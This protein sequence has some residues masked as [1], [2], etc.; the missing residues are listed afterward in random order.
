LHLGIHA[1]W[2]R[3]RPTRKERMRGA[4]VSVATQPC[5]FSGNGVC[6]SCIRGKYWQTNDYNR[7]TSPYQGHWQILLCEKSHRTWLQQ[8]QDVP[9][10]HDEVRGIWSWRTVMQQLL[11]MK[12]RER[13]PKLCQLCRH[14]S[15]F[16]LHSCG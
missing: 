10:W 3:A 8:F 15:E 5:A 16:Q 6:L 12:M 13:C 7:D 14:P 11:I 9:S 1:T 2:S 4:I